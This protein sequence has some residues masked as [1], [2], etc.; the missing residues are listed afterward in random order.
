MKNLSDL[1]TYLRETAFAIKSN[2]P[3]IKAGPRGTAYEEI[4]Q[5]WS[6]VSEVDQMRKAFRHHLIA[7]CEMRGM[8][9]DRI[10]KPAENNRPSED[11]IREIKELYTPVWRFSDENIHTGN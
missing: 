11:R 10:E 9:R 6:L 5:H 1:K 2:K 4:R 3:I 8:A 7:Y